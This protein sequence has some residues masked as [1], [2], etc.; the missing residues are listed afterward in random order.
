MD[1][2]NACEGDNRGMAI[3]LRLV[4]K[5]VAQAYLWW[6]RIGIVEVAATA[7]KDRLHH[8][9]HHYLRQHPWKPCE[10]HNS[11]DMSRIQFQ[12]IGYG[13]ACSHLL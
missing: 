13:T 3:A 11:N 7:R 12:L 4:Q 5:A 8:G 1:P 6:H 10:P 9:C 2:R